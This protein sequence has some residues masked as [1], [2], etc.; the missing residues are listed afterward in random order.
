MELPARWAAHSSRPGSLRDLSPRAHQAGGIMAHQAPDSYSHKPFR[1]PGVLLCF[2]GR[3]SRT[4]VTQW[5]RAA[6]GPPPPPSAREVGFTLSF[7]SCLRSRRIYC[8]ASAVCRDEE[9][10]DFGIALTG[11]WG[12]GP[13]RAGGRT[14]NDKDPTW[15]PGEGPASAGCL[16]LARMFGPAN[17]C[18][19][20]MEQHH[21]S[22]EV[23]S[24]GLFG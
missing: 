20:L 21:F 6:P 23:A 19:M 10:S 8:L 18:Q 15:R 17:P 12:P 2:T 4:Q 16:Q 9:D 5:A 14:I 11:Q 7:C 3:K 13:S 22:T 1:R 24:L